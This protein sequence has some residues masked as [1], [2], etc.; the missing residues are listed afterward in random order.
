M[1]YW[2]PF[3]EN[4]YLHLNPLTRQVRSTLPI[5]LPPQEGLKPLI[6]WMDIGNIQNKTTSFQTW[7]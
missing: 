5:Y 4:F 1:I 2:P 6:K 3:S 7:E